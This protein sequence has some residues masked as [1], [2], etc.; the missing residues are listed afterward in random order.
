MSA[1]FHWHDLHLSQPG[2]Q[3]SKSP[4]ALRGRGP[5]AAGRRAVGTRAIGRAI[6]P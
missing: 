3:A 6:W 4:R 5:P 1:L 2:R